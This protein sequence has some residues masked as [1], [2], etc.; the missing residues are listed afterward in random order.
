MRVAASPP[1][2]SS[3]LDNPLHQQPDSPCISAGCVGEHQVLDGI[4]II[5][6]SIQ[7][8]CF[9]VSSSRALPL[10]C[11]PPLACKPRRCAL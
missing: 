5:T 9:P 10:C 3:L 4:I 7:C 11:G 6:P 8:S 2:S 1:P